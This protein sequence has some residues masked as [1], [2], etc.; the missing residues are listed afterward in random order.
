[1]KMPSLFFHDAHSSPPEIRRA[2]NLVCNTLAF[3]LEFEHGFLELILTDVLCVET[4]SEDQ[5]GNLNSLWGES[6]LL[7]F[8]C[9]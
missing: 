5:Q 4:M 9:S 3:R 7:C 1:M 2:N 8:T 6:Q